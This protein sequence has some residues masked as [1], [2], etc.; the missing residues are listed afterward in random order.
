MTASQH[1]IDL[2]HD[3]LVSPQMFDLMSNRLKKLEEMAEERARSHLTSGR[4]SHVHEGPSAYAQQYSTNMMGNAP[5]PK[6][7]PPV[8]GHRGPDGPSSQPSVGLLGVAYSR[9]EQ[10]PV[11]AADAVSKTH[12]LRGSYNRASS[13]PPTGS[14]AVGDNST[15]FQHGSDERPVGIDEDVQP[16]QVTQPGTPRRPTPAPIQTQARPGTICSRS[17]LQPSL[18]NWLTL[19]RLTTPS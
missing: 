15:G 12:H 8:V 2:S 10:A 9:P 18:E 5:L 4:G 13:E 14:A 3:G 6:P 17:R 1:D 16:I 11:S 7:A 19:L